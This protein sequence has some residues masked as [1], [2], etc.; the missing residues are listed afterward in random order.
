MNKP[1]NNR[2]WDMNERRLFTRVLFE[3]TATLCFGGQQWP[4]ELLDLSLRGALVRE[5]PEWSETITSLTLQFQ[6]GEQDLAIEADVRHRHRQM[7]GLEFKLMDLD[8]ASLLRRLLELNLGD[9]QLL[10]RQ[11]QQL[12]DTHQSEAEK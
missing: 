3:H 6:L 7:L 11:Y 10:F 12:I 5:P 1:L 2:H 8:S 9:E 4:T